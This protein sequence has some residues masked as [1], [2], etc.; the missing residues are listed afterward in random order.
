MRDWDLRGAQSGGTVGQQAVSVPGPGKRTLTEQLP[1]PPVQ[2]KAAVGTTGDAAEREASGAAAPASGA[3]AP[4]SWK[5]D[6]EPPRVE[7][8]PPDILAALQEA[9]EVAE[10][11][12]SATAKGPTPPAEVPGDGGKTEDKDGA[13]AATGIATTISVDRFVGEAKKIQSKWGELT[14]EQRAGG[15]GK[16]ANAELT[17]A[18]VPATD[19]R[20]ADGMG[21]KGGQFVFQAW[22]LEMSKP[23]FSAPTIDDEKSSTLAS[24]IYHEARHAEQWHLMARLLGGKGKTAAQIVA[25]TQIKADIA[26]D[27]VK[28]PIA[29]GG[30]EAKTA[31]SFYQSV[32]GTGKP[33]REATLKELFKT[34]DANTKAQQAYDA[35]SK[36]PKATP[37]TKAAA[38][39]KW[40]DSYQA[41]MAAHAVYK[42]LPEEADAF[43]TGGAVESKYKAKP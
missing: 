26:A 37:E 12:A 22:T 20:L 27:A 10:T 15:L 17:N 33:H 1:V 35:S 36:D 4:T 28:K 29:A 41:F 7:Q 6:G 32:Y 25:A 16:A 21:V 38:L 18:N 24:Q 30:A 34:G 23:N 9:A 3:T 39:K 31:D 40:Q 43:K 14:A 2:A 42:A 13:A 8:F 11:G 5:P 19:S